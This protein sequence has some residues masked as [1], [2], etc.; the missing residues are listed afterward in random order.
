M[1]VS[2]I[3]IDMSWA[4]PAAITLL[5]RFFKIYVCNLI[6]LKCFLYFLFHIEN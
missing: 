5:I 3:Q 2:M 4:A 1:V 6:F